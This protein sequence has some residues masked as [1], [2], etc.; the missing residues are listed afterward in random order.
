MIC[1]IVCLGEVAAYGQSVKVPQAGLKGLSE[2][3][4]YLFCR[5]TRSKAY[6]LARGFNRA[7]TASTHVGIGF[8]KGQRF[9]IYNVVDE[10]PPGKSALV[11]SS[12]NAFLSGEDLFYFSLWECNN[13]PRALSV[14]KG[15]LRTYEGRKITFDVRFQIAEDDT[16]Y[17]SEFCAQ[18]LTRAGVGRFQ[19][20][21]RPLDDPLFEAVLDRKII[22]YYPVDFF[23]ASEGVRKVFEWYRK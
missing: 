3:K 15:I 14:L 1:L 2:G 19:P 8:L 4:I 11:V 12:L 20:F 17:C 18:V 5:G 13:N 10:S 9:V 7:D 6:L 23:Q 16:L 21:T 22:R